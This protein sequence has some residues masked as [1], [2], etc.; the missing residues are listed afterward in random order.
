MNYPIWKIID[1]HG[2]WT[3]KTW[4]C[5]YELKINFNESKFNFDELPMDSC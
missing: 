4:L 1:I 3:L 2:Q 5:D